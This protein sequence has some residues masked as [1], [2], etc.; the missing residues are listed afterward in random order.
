MQLVSN[1]NI[2]FNYPKT[3]YSQLYL[4]ASPHVPELFQLVAT[5]LAAYNT[6]SFAIGTP[7]S[8]THAYNAFSNITFLVHKINVVHEN[9]CLCIRKLP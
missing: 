8:Q 5:L 7:H 1:R 2:V 6:H 9:Q 4:L 3:N